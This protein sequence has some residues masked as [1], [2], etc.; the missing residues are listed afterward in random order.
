[1]P[2]II[3]GDPQHQLY[4][5][6][7]D[8]IKMNNSINIIGNR[9]NSSAVNLQPTSPNRFNYD[10]EVLSQTRKP[11]MESITENFKKRKMEENREIFRS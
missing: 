10:D 4:H 11:K 5:I 8:Q 3:N 9:K 2:L 6:D 1:M 7:N